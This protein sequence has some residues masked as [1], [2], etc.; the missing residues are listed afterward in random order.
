[1]LIFFFFFFFFPSEK[2]FF[3]PAENSESPEEINVVLRKKMEDALQLVE[4]YERKRSND[5]VSYD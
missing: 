3:L 1:M 4:E 2:K 5:K